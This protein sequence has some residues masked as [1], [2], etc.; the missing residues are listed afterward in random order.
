MCKM[1]G[2]LA[3]ST[4]H[5]FPECTECVQHH[6][7]SFPSLHLSSPPPSYMH[8]NNS[9][10]FTSLP[11]GDSEAKIR[12][13]PQ[14]KGNSNVATDKAAQPARRAAGVTQNHRSCIFPLA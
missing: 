3:D 1:E 9:L 14:I 8:T 12:K 11:D 7:I 5:S 2:Q 6:P 10:T 13:M 4:E